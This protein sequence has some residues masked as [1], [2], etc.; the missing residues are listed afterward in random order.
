MQAQII[1]APIGRTPGTD[2]RIFSWNILSEELTPD[3]PAIATRIGGIC[4]ILLQYLPDAAGIQEI[5]ESA[6][7]LFAEQIGN[8]YEFVNPKTQEGNFSFTGIAY[9]RDRCRLLESDI[10]NYPQGNRRI[11]LASWI[12]LE[13]KESGLRFV[14]LSTH[15]DRHACNR[16]MQAEYMG[17]MVRR[18]EE[19]FG[20][21][22]ICTGD[23]NARENSAAFRTFMNISHHGE[24]KY[25]CAQPVNKCFTG[26]NVGSFTP[27]FEGEE[28][29]DHIT[30]TPGVSVLHY[31][32]VIND[33]TVWLSD[34]FPLYADLCLAPVLGRRLCEAQ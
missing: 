31:E 9:N 26:H 29:I 30:V 32:T 1:S 18:L 10:Q 23:F 2:I 7:A 17:E 6:Y 28:S 22:V 27:Q 16:P 15:W 12:Y 13:K 5:S 25:L 20:V 3:A 19:R 24:A 14:L 34:H 21:P 4:N 11:R 8:R 33:K